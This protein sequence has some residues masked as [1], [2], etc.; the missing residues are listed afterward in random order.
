MKRELVAVLALI[1]APVFRQSRPP[2]KITPQTAT[3]TPRIVNQ[4][5]KMAMTTYVLETIKQQEQFVKNGGD[6]GRWFWLEP[7]PQRVPQPRLLFSS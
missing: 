1:A 6:P 7:P 3:R 5:M 4:T 2:K